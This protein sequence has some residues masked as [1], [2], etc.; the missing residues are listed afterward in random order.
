MS[1]LSQGNCN[2]PTSVSTLD[3]LRNKFPSYADVDQEDTAITRALVESFSLPP[4]VDKYIVSAASLKKRLRQSKKLVK[5]GIDKLR[6]EHLYAL[7][8]L[9][10]PKPTDLE[11][12]VSFL[13][14]AIITHIANGNIPT[15]TLPFFQDNELSAI[16]EKVRPVCVCGVLRKLGALE[17][18]TNSMPFNKEY[19][20]DVN[21]AFEPSGPDQIVHAMR[22]A[23]EIYPMNDHF[24]ADGINAFNSCNRSKAFKMIINNYPRPFP[25]IRAMYNTPSNVWYYGLTDQIHPVSC[26]IGAQQGDVWGT[27]IYCMALQP[28][29]ARLKT[30]LGPEGVA[31]FFVDDSNYCA[32]HNLMLETILTIRS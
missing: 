18:F 12:T 20:K 23:L 15:K 17:G 27:W 21:L 11:D 9:S 8:G 30:A 26:E 31:L 25:H 16:G 29:F 7:T 22:T 14:A 3:T 19:F 13:L 5:H 32:P 4:H 28:L 2:T 24:Y 6:Y 10:N 1:L